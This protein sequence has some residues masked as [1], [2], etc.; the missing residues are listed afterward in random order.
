M[1]RGASTVVCLVG[2]VRE[3]LL[4]EVA[5]SP[6]VSVVR[7]E[8][9]G[10]EA[11]LRASASAEGRAAPFVVLAA[12]PLHAVAREWRAMWEPGTDR[13]AFELRAGEAVAAWRAGRLQL[14]DYYLVVAA[15][16]PGA[17]PAPHPLDLHLGVLRGQRPSRVVLVV[18][19]EERE[20]AA[21]VLGALRRLGQGPWWPPLDELVEAARSYFPAAVGAR[22]A[23]VPGSS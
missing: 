7:P 6:N 20:E 18:A 19:G 3:G 2:E 1:R 9:E 12:D 10:F 22:A 17:E 8:G 4:E 14:P 11:A 15:E 5:R 23:D 21:R 16:R 13:S